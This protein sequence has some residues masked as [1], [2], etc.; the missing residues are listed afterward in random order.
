MARMGTGDLDNYDLIVR[1]T[2]EVVTDEE[3]REIAEDP[4]GK[5]AYV[6]YEPSGALHIGH[7]LTANKLIDLQKAGMDVVVL[8]ADVHAY[9]N[10][11]GTFD[12]IQ[13]T[14]E[15][16]REQLI[17][18]G[19]DTGAT[20]F[21]LG[22]EF[23]LDNDYILDVHSL[24]VQVTLN[25]AR[26]SMSEVA[27][28]KE[29]TNVGQMWYPLMQAVDIARLDVDLAVGGIDQRKIHMLAR[30]HLSD[31]DYETPTALHTPLLTS[32]DKGEDKMSATVTENE[33][34]PISVDDSSEEIEEKVLDAHCPSQADGN[35][36][37]EIYRYHV[38]P[39]FETVTVERTDE[40]GG[41][42]EYTSYE[43]FARDIDR[44]ELHPQDAK[45]GLVDYLDHLVEECRD[46]V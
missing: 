22:S 33:S 38:F 39:R 11:K 6:G 14:A 28:Q 40:Y 2:E 7:M 31:I 30:D 16:M 34:D 13:M 10:E 3:V 18:F 44:G 36:I 12:E 1:N 43:E 32:L 24:A 29:N 23:Q 37:A 19:L 5:R 35:P 41:D 27:R 17:A 8:L 9:L 25:R 42:L 15:R 21:V 46:V 45:E 26:R 4:E 20:E